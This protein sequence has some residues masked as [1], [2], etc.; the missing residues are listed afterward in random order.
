M[1]NAVKSSH[2]LDDKSFFLT[3]TDAAYFLQTVVQCCTQTGVSTQQLQVM[4]Y[5]LEHAV[6]THHL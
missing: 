1:W 6:F 5:M 4:Y 3:V 2:G